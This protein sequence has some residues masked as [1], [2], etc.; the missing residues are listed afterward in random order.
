MASVH[1]LKLYIYVNCYDMYMCEDEIVQ[2][3]INIYLSIFATES[4]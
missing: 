4:R 1:F 2:F 3:K